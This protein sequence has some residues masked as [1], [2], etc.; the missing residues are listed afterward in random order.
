MEFEGIRNMP[1]KIYFIP[2][3]FDVLINE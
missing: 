3:E 2:S 1:V